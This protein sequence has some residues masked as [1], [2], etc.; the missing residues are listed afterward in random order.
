MWT[1]GIGTS[2]PTRAPDSQ[3]GQ[4]NARLTGFY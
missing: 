1:D 4:N 3:F 2:D